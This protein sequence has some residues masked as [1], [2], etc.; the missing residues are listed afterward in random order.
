M[1]ITIMLI[2][3]ITILLG[4]Q[5]KTEQEKINKIQEEQ[6][7]KT[8]YKIITKSFWQPNFDYNKTTK[9][10]IRIDKNGKFTYKIVE[11]SDIE[12]FNNYVKN[13]LEE[14]SKLKYPIHPLKE[15]MNIK[16]DFIANDIELTEKQKRIIR[17]Y[18]D[19]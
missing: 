10:K 17:Q 12:K 18:K 19:N 8:I 4:N 11:N 13:Y 6:Y 3:T 2:L 5:S 1:K 14:Q 16:M 7:K 15:E 9:V